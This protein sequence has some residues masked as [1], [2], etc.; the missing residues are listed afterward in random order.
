MLWWGVHA[1]NKHHANVGETLSDPAVTA[2][3]YRL[4]TPGQVRYLLENSTL[5]LPTE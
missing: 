2:R 1:W 4:R 3:I 5:A